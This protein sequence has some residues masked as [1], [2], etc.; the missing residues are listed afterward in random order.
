[1]SEIALVGCAHIHTPAFAK[2]LQNRHDITVSAVWD[3]DIER[4]S[5]YATDLGA[6][7][8]RDLNEI[9][10]DEAISAVVICEE[11]HLHA[12]LVL[13][14]CKASKHQFV[15]KPL[16]FAAADAS[17][18]ATALE[19]A[20]V[21]FQTGYFMRGSPHFQFARHAIR[22]GH[23]G[24]I[25]RVRLSN[26]HQGSLEDWFTPEWLWMTDP[27]KAGTGAFGDLGTHI[28]DILLW[29]TEGKVTGAACVTRTAMARYGHQCDEYGEALLAFDNGM[30]ATL[31]AGWVD[32]A[33]PVKLLISGTAGHLYVVEDK[34][35]LKS[36]HL[37]GADGTT[38]WTELPEQLPHAFDLFLD[39]IVG[40]E[41][42]A[43]LDQIPLVTPREAARRSVVMEA[44][45]EAAAKE[46][47]VSIEE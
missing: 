17:S 37:D 46:R 42:P 43:G 36:N 14:A 25:T 6:R 35:F 20:G 15:E 4:A 19:E 45:Y 9:W 24:Q 23:L 7:V 22:Q 13:A 21:I 41:P 33:D 12:P 8:V 18:M 28:L 5:R 27:A 30:V 10:R 44:L 26:G 32:I 16:G 39:A 1:M 40:A 34:L 38:A 3:R 31:A 29:L 47:W 2:T 11:T